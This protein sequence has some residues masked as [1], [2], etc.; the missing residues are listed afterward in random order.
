MLM[1]NKVWYYRDKA[2]LSVNQLSRK[3]GITP[4]E[5]TKIENGQT[6]DVMLS[7]AIR[8]SNSLNVDIYE[9]FCISK[10]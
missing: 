6:N 1:E 3:T 8:L 4:S 7:N 2:N 10:R 5:I 9:L